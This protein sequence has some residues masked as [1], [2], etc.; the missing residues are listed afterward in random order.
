[1]EIGE[2]RRGVELGQ[3]EPAIRENEIDDHVFKT[4]TAEGSR[5]RAIG[6]R[7]K[8]LD[9]IG[10]LRADVPPVLPARAQPSS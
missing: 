8:L 9:A 5:A 7:R 6:H 3:Y 10:A 2:W 4:L 1:M